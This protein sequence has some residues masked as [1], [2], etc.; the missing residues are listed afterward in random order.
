MKKLAVAFIV[1]LSVFIQR[2]AQAHEPHCE[3]VS[4]P[5]V[6]SP[7]ATKVY[8]L[9]G[10]LCSNGIVQGKTIQVLVHGASFDHNYWDFPVKPNKYSYVKYMTD[11]GYAVLNLDRIGYGD[12]SR[13]FGDDLH[14]LDLHVA[15][16]TVHQVV[17]VLHSG[18]FFVSGFGPVGLLRERVE[19]VGH[20][21]GSLVVAIEAST[22]KDV[23]AVIQ[24]GIS[25][26]PGPAG[27]AS[28]G[29]AEQACLDAK[30][31]GLP[32]DADVSNPPTGFGYE[33]DVPVLP[34]PP[35]GDTW[36]FLFFQGVVEP[37]V[38]AKAEELRQTFT[39]AEIADI[40][41]SLGI[42]D[43]TT[44]A[45][46]GI[47]V[48]TLLVNG[49]LD[50]LICQPGY[51]D[52]DAVLY[53]NEASHYAPE[54]CFE[55]KVVVGSGHVLN[56]HQVAPTWFGIAKTWSDRRVGSAVYKPATEPCQ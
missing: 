20:S 35:F 2:Q 27:F 21:I 33:V 4:F 31:A 5:V 6:L 23:D 40:T 34:F 1:M 48:P 26:F 50:S 43:P 7:H 44:D 30:F 29:L 54:A 8:K 52:T 41:V 46:T 14:T 12:S 37:Q 49:T 47:N 25:H 11:A 38:F 42:P 55:A 13:P 22:Y 56:L 9:S 24:S 16:Y 17:K 3:D 19:L 53:A 28:F 18:F 36:S 10:S 32:C 51:C 39:A 15:A 45:T